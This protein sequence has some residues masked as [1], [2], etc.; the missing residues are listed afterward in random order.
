MN[1]V[2][3]QKEAAIAEDSAAAAEVARRKAVTA[4]KAA[5]VA[6]AGEALKAA[7]EQCGA[8][9]VCGGQ[10]CP[11]AGMKRCATCFDVKTRM[12]VKR[13]CVAARRPLML[14]PPAEVLAL[15]SPPAPPL[16]SGVPQLVPEP[17]I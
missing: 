16:P 14:M 8:A 2:L 5:E 9:C 10:P 4:A 1:E 17:A 3:Q 6:D 11:V 15:P 7:W 12:C 13:Q